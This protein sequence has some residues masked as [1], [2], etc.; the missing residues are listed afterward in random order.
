[1]NLG[2]LHLP[3]FFYVKSIS[4]KVKIIYNIT[5]SVILGERNEKKMEV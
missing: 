2:K 5:Q 1:V 4:K 3:E